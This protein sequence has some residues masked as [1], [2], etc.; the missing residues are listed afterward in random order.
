MSRSNRPLPRRAFGRV[1]IGAAAAGA[2]PSG[3]AFA[4]SGFPDRTVRIV[5]GGAPGGGTDFMARLL[6]ERLSPRWKQPVVVENRAGASGVIGSKYVM[7]SPPDGYTMI[8]GHTSTHAI[9]PAL[10]DPPPYD[11]V[12]DFTAVAQ[13]AVAPDLLVVA[14]NSPFRSVQDVIALARS[15]PGEVTYGSPGVGLSQHLRGFLLA[16]TAGVE[17]RHVPYKG[18]APALQDLLGGHITIMFATAGG[19]VQ[20]ARDGRVRVIGVSSPKRI[21][22]FPDAPTMTE[23]GFPDLEGQGFFG[24]FGPAGMPAAVVQ[25]IG[26]GVASVLGEPDVRAK[27]ETQFVEPV[28]STPEQFAEFHR[29]MVERWK[30][31][32]QASGVKTAG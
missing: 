15:K 13:V 28:I 31:I 32:V 30:K 29:S 4:Q 3:R 1:L 8:M 20:Q 18:T 11:P 12:R 5:V 2:L 10:M 9:V 22:M 19:I 21:P 25:T 17:M 27:F 24:L 23:L 26:S 16:K 14:A 6:A 7:T